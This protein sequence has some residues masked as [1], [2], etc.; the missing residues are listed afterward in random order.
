MGQLRRGGRS[1]RSSRR[2][3]GVIALVH[4]DDQGVE[5]LLGHG[6]NHSVS[7]LNLVAGTGLLV[8]K[9]LHHARRQQIAA[10][11]EQAAGRV[12]SGGL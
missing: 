9:G 11:G 8:C 6:A 2:G 1:W 3:A 10:D 4:V 12:L 5:L 7:E